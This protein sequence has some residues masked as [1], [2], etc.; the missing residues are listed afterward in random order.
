VKPRTLGL[1]IGIT[2]GLVGITSALVAIFLNFRTASTREPFTARLDAG[3][4][5]LVSTEAASREYGEAIAEAR[6]LH[7]GAA[8][9]IFQPENLNPVED[10]F[11]QNPPRYALVFILPDQLDVNFA[12]RWLK[13][14]TEIDEDPFVDVRTG[15]ITGESAGAAASFIRRIRE[16]VEAKT[17]LAGLAVDNLGPNTM[18]AKSAFSQFRGNFM[19]PVLG[20]R[21]G[22]STISHGSEAFNSERLSS[23]GGAGLIHF[24]GHGYPDRIVEGAS[25]A[26][27][28]Q[29]KLGPCV[30]FNGAC[31]TGVTG[32]WFDTQGNV[33]EQ[34]VR[35]DQSFCLG[36]LANQV[37]GYLAALHPDHG[38]PV[39]QEMEFLA[40]DGGSLGDLM[41][42]THD[43]VILGA[44]GKLP[45][46]EPF[47]NA[48]PNPQWSP[49]DVMLKG[50]ASR[51]LF[52]DPGLMLMPHFTAPA[53]EIKVR[54][55]NPDTLLVTAVLQNTD[56]KATFTDT[57]HADLSSDPNLF[58]DRALIICKL[59]PGWQTARTVEI[60]QVT[61]RSKPLKSRLVAFGVE[62]DGGNRLLQVQVDVPTTGYMQSDFRTSG[63]R[64]ELKVQR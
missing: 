52:G 41:K 7:P 30:A 43:G 46:L 44:G 28:R 53:F 1:V 4:Y 51:V 55:E 60:V 23:L 25:G 16:A 61:A 12:W 58:N 35:A 33:T 64:V 59:P 32:R 39:Y 26:L 40:T 13:M 56:L 42:H 63:A 17:P 48:A 29:L 54:T 57:Y 38:V 14:T 45:S 2:G 37:L 62:Q 9:I 49:S 36:M 34:H 8:E 5:A 47:A 10:A 11:K 19:I 50:T 22:L 18:A 15:F 6:K 31:Y 24:G 27:A 20:Q 21:L 3:T